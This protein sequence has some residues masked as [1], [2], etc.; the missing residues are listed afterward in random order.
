MNYKQIVFL[1]GIVAVSAIFR[2]TGINWDE[3]AHLHPDE[4]FLTMVETSMRWPTTVT[5]YFDT[6][7]SM[8][9]PHNIGF[10]FYVYGTYP[11]Y[12]AKLAAQAV[13]KDTYD[14]ITITGRALSAFV[15]MLTLG[16]VAL[17]AYSVAS[18]SGKDRNGR[19]WAA[20]FAA[21]G[22][23]V[24]VLPIQLSHF[25]TVDPYVTFFTAVVL[26]RL[27]RKKADVL[28]GIAA[29]F[30]VGA[31]VSAVILIP[32]FA[33]TYLVLWPW[34]RHA[35]SRRDISR[36][37]GTGFFAAVGFLVTLRII[38]PYLFDG[39]GINPLTLA[40]WRQLSS[41][42]Q[43]GNTFPP[44]LQWNGV[45]F[46]Q[47]L[48]GM[49]ALGLGIPL[50]LVAAAGIVDWVRNVT[51]SI[52]HPAKTLPRFLYPQFLLLLWAV[53]VIV[54]QALQ[55]SKPLRYFWPVYPAVAVIAGWFLAFRMRRNIALT[56]CV[57]LLYWP[58]AYGSIYLHPQ[59]RI[60][61][62]DW[63]YAHI[64]EGSTIAW[65]AW[66]DPIP[67]ARQ[68]NSLG[69]YKTPQLPV[70]DPDSPRKWATVAAILTRAD[71][72]VL[73]SNRGYGA[74]GNV[75]SR[76]PQSYRYYRLLFSGQLGFTPVMR[77]VSRPSIPFPGTGLCIPIPFL[78]YGTLARSVPSC[79][80]GAISFVDD[81]AD[82][83]FTVYDHPSV[84]IFRKTKA[85]DYV[86]LLS[87]PLTG[88]PDGR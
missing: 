87:A 56:V 74:I 4:R 33:V 65:E 80:P 53:S 9:N 30:A 64:P 16:I 46:W 57:I 24:M 67:V 12:A 81:E 85:V 18:V 7:S 60:Q 23:G 83:T 26:Y 42:D 50:G 76:Y 8:L 47:P 59:T 73:S 31:K 86:G 14:G 3:N 1:I 32:L 48:W 72:V 45:S 15:D 35:T 55:F 44:G 66:D 84:I 54:Y 27:V 6:R 63:I 11:V 5:Q 13:G 88:L 79:A 51:G 77:F 70:F 52:T 17:I 75:R 78:T 39:F 36:L 43:P 41:F 19:I 21:F 22:Y 10:S 29:A 82:E 68:G 25:F 37:I 40:N 20:L 49:I 61:A 69:R 62:S 38:Y 34:K 58:I 2:F 28:T 71:Y